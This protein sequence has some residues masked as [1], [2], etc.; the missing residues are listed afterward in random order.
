MCAVEDRNP[1]SPGVATSLLYG[2]RILLFSVA[3]GLLEKASH[4]FLA[5]GIG[6]LIWVT[7]KFLDAKRQA[8]SKAFAFQQ[9]PSTRQDFAI[10]AAA[11]GL[12]FV[13]FATLLSLSRGGTVALLL[14]ATMIGIALLAIVDVVPEET[15]QFAP[16]ALLAIF[17]QV[18]LGRSRVCG[19]AVKAER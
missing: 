9:R 13:V 1:R 15:A 8:A 2:S 7:L 5:L 3:Q 11:L 6:P 18:W 17:P 16:L 10:G 4:Q 14:A 19:R 12:G